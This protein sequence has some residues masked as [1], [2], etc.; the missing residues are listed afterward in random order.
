MGTVDVVFGK[1]VGVHIDDNV[2]TDSG[3][4]DILKIRPLARLGYF[5]YT[6][7]TSVFQMV[8]P[9]SERL[10]IGLEGAAARNLR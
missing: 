9:D 4:L 5:D 6:S 3:R 1:V 7:V 2:L 10:L 8:I